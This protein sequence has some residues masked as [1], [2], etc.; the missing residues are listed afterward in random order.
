M[1][2][3]TYQK[4]Q[5]IKEVSANNVKKIT[6]IIKEVEELELDNL[7]GAAFYQDI[8]DNYDTNNTDQY[9]DLVEGS[10]FVDCNGDTVKHKGLWYLLAYLNYAEYVMEANIEDTFTGFVNKVRTDSQSISNGVMNNLRNKNREMAFNYYN[11]T[12]DYLEENSDLFPLYKCS[13]EKRVTNFKIG[14]VRK[15]KR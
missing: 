15:T 12:R 4:Q 14:S 5:E 8:V 9:K 13:K 7:L 6:Q 10:T 3:L 11:K 1:T 2:I